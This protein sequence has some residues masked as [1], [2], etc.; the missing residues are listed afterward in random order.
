VVVV[1]TM[2]V[3]ALMVAV[4]ALSMSPPLVSFGGSF[5]D[6]QTSSIPSR[7]GEF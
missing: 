2:V 3:A 5:W 1:A 7:E 4:V 6:N